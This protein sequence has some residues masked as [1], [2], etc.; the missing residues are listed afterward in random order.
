MRR[1]RR[2]AV[3][4]QFRGNVD[5][6]HPDQRGG[7]VLLDRHR[8]LAERDFDE[9]L[10]QATGH[11]LSYSAFRQQDFIFTFHSALKLEKKY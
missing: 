5:R 2:P 8:R 1:R 6:V 4:W 11:I 9:L 3:A 7:Q 10:L